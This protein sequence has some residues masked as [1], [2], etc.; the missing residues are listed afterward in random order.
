MATIQTRAVQPPPKAAAISGNG[1]LVRPAWQQ[2]FERLTDK[3]PVFQQFSQTITP[4]AVSANSVSTQTFT[5]TG[6][7]TSDVVILNHAAFVYGIS[8]T[9]ARVSANDTL[10]ITYQNITGGSITPASMTYYI[11]AIRR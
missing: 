8:I 10:E 5:V 3:V 11:M 2:W 4:T 1:G 6:L 9:A 7:R